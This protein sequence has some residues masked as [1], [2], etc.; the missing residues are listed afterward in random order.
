MPFN[1]AG[2]DEHHG[3]NFDWNT[4]EWGVEG[5]LNMIIGGLY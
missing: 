3:R 5:G 2:L 4:G 1:L